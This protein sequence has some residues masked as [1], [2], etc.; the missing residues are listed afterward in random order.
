[1]LGFIRKC[2]FTAITF[3][4]ISNINSLKFFSRNIQECK[5]RPE[6]INLNTNEPLFYLYSIKIN[7][8]KGSCNTI[9]DPYAK[10][11]LPD[12]IKSTNVKVF[13]LI[14]RTNETR[15]IK[16]HKTCKCKC[17]L[18]ASVC[19]N[20]QRWNENKCRCE[21]KDLIVKGMCDKGFIW[22]PS[23]CEC[24]CDKSYD[25]GEYLDYKNFKCRRKIIDKLIEECSENIDENK[26]L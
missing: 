18:D 2:F 3:F 11:C 14:S 22:N 23:N 1:M 4:N 9:N 25:I 7:K 20:K 17:R 15:H 5:I 12:N 19:N 16:W 21:C 10:I 6:I 8:C 13:N 24:E 26:M